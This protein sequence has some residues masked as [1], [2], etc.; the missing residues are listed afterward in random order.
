MFFDAVFENLY[1][2]KDCADNKAEGNIIDKIMLKR[3]KAVG[4]DIDMKFSPS[5]RVF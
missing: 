4:F 2:N 1:R 5:D 3:R